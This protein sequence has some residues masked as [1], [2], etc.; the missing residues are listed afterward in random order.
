MKHMRVAAER[1][2]AATTIDPAL[3]YHLR[4]AI[5]EQWMAGKALSLDVQAAHRFMY[6]RHLALAN[7]RER[8]NLLVADQAPEPP[9]D[10]L[11]C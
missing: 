5:Q 1:Q 11:G 6:R 10:I 9:D 3:G 7:A 2:A 8:D 4:R